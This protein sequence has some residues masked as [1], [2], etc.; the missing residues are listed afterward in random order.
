[1]S[2]K[3]NVLVLIPATLRPQIFER[4]LESFFNYSFTRSGLKGVS[5]IGAIHIDE[6]GEAGATSSEIFSMAINY[7]GGIPLHKIREHDHS[8]AG[9]FHWLWSAAARAPVDYV[10]YLEDDWQLM[11]PVNLMHMIEVMEKHPRLATL[12]LNFKPAA[13]DVAKQWKHYFE[14][15]GDYF[16]CSEDDKKHIG[17]CGHPG[18]VRP[19][20]I[21]ETFHLLKPTECP[22]RQMKGLYGPTPMAEVI[23]RWEYGVYGYKP[24]HGPFIMDIGREWRAKRNIIKQRDTSWRSVKK[25]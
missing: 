9:A 23:D 7:F 16:Q 24:P 18:M 12:R 3:Y 20:F 22:E 21:R 4:T 2:T 14:W 6:I 25:Q 13:R 15:N 8:L 1:M 17:W 19:Q 5:V 11:R 10:F